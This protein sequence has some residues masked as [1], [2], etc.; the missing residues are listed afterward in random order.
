ML[1][2]YLQPGLSLCCIIILVYRVV[3]INL[4]NF[5]LLVCIGTGYGGILVLF[6]LCIV[7]LLCYI[8]Y[9]IICYCFIYLIF[10]CFHIHRRIFIYYL[11]C[12]S[13]YPIN[14]RISCLCIDIPYHVM[15]FYPFS[16]KYSC[17]PTL[18]GFFMRLGNGCSGSK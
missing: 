13:F 4:F 18:L 11:V 17:M 9:C 5:S 15:S 12:D 6:A 2:I 7:C 10:I 3:F 1:F 14:V 16:I 8:N